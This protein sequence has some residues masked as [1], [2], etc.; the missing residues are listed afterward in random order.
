MKIKS[1]RAFL[2]GGI[3]LLAGAFYLIIRYGL[4][5]LHG[6][7]DWPD[8]LAVLSLLILAPSLIGNKLCLSFGAAAGY[9]CGFLIGWLFHSFD[10]DPGGGRTD[11]L[12]LIWTAVLLVFIGAGALA[13]AASPARNKKEGCA[14]K[15]KQK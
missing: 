5:G 15:N 7:K 8:F 3:L 11:N 1:G 12:W 9:P 4:F 6:M 2:K 13:E 14:G 10:T